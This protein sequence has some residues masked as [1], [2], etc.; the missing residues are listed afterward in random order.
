LINPIRNEV[1]L[2]WGMYGRQ[3]RRA[4]GFGGELE[5]KK[6]HGKSRHRWEHDIKMDPREIGWGAWT[7][8][9]WLRTGKVVGFCVRVMNIGIS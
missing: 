7:G 3:E 4:K 1:G 8:L 9:V 5:G 6:Q 2:A